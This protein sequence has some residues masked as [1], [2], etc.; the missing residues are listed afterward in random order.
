MK[1]SAGAVWLSLTAVFCLAGVVLAADKEEWQK[2]IPYL[3]GMSSYEIQNADDKDFDQYKF[4]TGKKVETVEGKVWSKY[5]MLKDNAT[6]ASDIQIIRNY[7]NAVR[8]MGG[9]ILFQ[10]KSEDVNCEDLSL[11]QQFLTGKVV[12]AGQELWIEVVPCD[13]GGDYRL[14]VVEKEAMKQDVTAG[15]LLRALNADGHVALYINFDTGKSTIRPESK[16]IID[17]VVA[18]LKGNPGLT[19]GVEGHTDNVGD[20][21]RNKVLSEDRA[22][23][24]MAAIVSQGV[25]ANRLSAAG[26][27]QDKPIADN[28]TDEG[29]AKNRRVELVKK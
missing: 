7:A 9:T 17:Q 14:V 3:S 16:P 6:Q 1:R 24:V 4:C 28:K 18:L 12:M 13:G 22:K 19:L 27:G 21:R 11:C 15:E 5:Y 26:F 10:G 8:N 29:K 23:A 25:D 2:D 20:P